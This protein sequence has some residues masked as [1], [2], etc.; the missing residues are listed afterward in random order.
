MHHVVKIQH[1]AKIMEGLI[2]KNPKKL[3][4]KNPMSRDKF[5]AMDLG[6]GEVMSVINMSDNV[7]YRTL[8]E[9]A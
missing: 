6:R 4:R 7:H 5:K 2:R 3:I 1:L 9:F 8:E